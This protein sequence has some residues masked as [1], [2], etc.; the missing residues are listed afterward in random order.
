MSYFDR[1]NIRCVLLCNYIELL[2]YVLKLEME[3]NKKH[4]FSN[5]I[6]KYPYEFKDVSIQDLRIYFNNLT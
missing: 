3:L 5:I 2:L 1:K 4:R 6:N